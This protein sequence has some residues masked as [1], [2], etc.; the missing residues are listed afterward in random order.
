MM[1]LED[2]VCSIEQA[3]KLKELG[4]AQESLFYYTHSEKWGI[5]P[6]SSI[7]FKGDP[8][9]T[10]TAA[11][12]ILMLDNKVGNID[13]V[14]VCEGDYYA[15]SSVVSIKDNKSVHKFFDTFSQ[16]LANK[17]IMSIEHGW[18][19][20]ADANKRLLKDINENNILKSE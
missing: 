13:R 6:R 11:E 14:Y 12:L 2:Q 4:V 16:A 9:S 19:T 17:L 10:F 20:V 3:V 1:K 5:M 8:T 18:L 15:I 7:D